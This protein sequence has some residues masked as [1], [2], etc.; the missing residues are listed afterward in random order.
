MLKAEG[1]EAAYGYALGRNLALAYFAEGL[2]K[3][4]PAG[5]DA[6]RKD[7]DQRI[8]TLPSGAGRASAIRAAFDACYAREGGNAPPSA[9][10]Q[11]MAE[12]KYCKALFA[13]ISSVLTEAP[14]TLTPD[15]KALYSDF[16]RI[17][18]ELDGPGVAFRTDT[19]QIDERQ[20]A[21][22]EKK[23]NADLDARL[24]AG[25]ND[26]VLGDAVADCYEEYRGGRLGLAVK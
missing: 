2:Q 5:F 20:A 13:D 8:A 23:K 14:D 10:A 3:S 16:A 6:A 15:S 21:D 24:K 25:S 12:Q 17:A 1:D 19:T 11:L 18:R 26:E 7:A 22:L 4:N 9:V